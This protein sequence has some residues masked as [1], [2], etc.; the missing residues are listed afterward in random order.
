[1]KGKLFEFNPETK[2]WHE[3]GIGMFKLNKSKKTEKYRISNIIIFFHLTFL[4]MRTDGVQK[5]VLNSNLFPKMICEIVQE[6]NIRFSANNFESKIQTF[7]LRV[8]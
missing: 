3:R 1:M 6:K 8:L 5:L 7:I 2:D 4:V